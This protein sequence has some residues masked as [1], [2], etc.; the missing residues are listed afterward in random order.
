MLVALASWRGQCACLPQRRFSDLGTCIL[1]GV[2]FRS[3][4]L[5]PGGGLDSSVLKRCSRMHA[6]A[7]TDGEGFPP[8]KTA[9]G[10]PAA[11]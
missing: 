1:R 10:R 4:V 2:S 3:S 8:A 9:G 7:D 6:L 5:L 11:R